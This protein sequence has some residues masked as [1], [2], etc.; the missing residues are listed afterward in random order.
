MKNKMLKKIYIVLIM[1][2][3]IVANTNITR[4]ASKTELNNQS[5]ELDEKIH[6]AEAEL[7][8]IQAELTGSLKEV[9]DLTAK[10]NEYEDAISVLNSQ[11]SELES[12][13]AEREEEISKKEKEQKEQQKLLETRLAAMYEA[14]GSMSY[15]DL[16]LSSKSLSSFISNYYIMSEIAEM[17]EELLN[18]IE[19]NKKEIEVAKEKLEEEKIKVENNKNTQQAKAD[20]LKVLQKEKQAKVAKLNGDEKKLQ[21]KIDQ[22]EKD[23]K[24]IEN[25]LAAIL[26]AERENNGGN[27]YIFSE[28]SEAGYIFPVAGLSKANIRNKNYPSYS[29]HT[30]VDVNI[31]VTGKKVVAV[32]DGTVRISTA[33]RNSDG[34][35]RSYG[36]YIVIDHHDGT[37][38]LYAHG[39]AGSRQVQKNEKVKQGQVI[40]TVGSTGNSTGN[41]LHFEVRVNLKPVNPLPYLP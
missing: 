12:S 36:E 30:G 27:E 23:K 31:N 22:F 8:G 7:D 37:M 32:K 14:G 39:L 26:A 28:P 6:E 40:M 13:I 41:H 11:I 16:L 18:S 17:D 24:D 15:L 3:I 33:L 5:D 4:A 20:A 10:V 34:T 25:E 35:Y 19:K 38:T 2:V 1:A 29:G 9:Q 21:A